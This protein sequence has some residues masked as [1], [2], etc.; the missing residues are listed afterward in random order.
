MNSIVEGLLLG[1]DTM[2]K[3]EVLA[4]LSCQEFVDVMMLKLSGYNSRLTE[5]VISILLQL[6]QGN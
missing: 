4:C 5:T 1:K 6:M 2:D 3:T